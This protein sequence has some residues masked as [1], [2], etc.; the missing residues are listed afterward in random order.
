MVESMPENTNF[1]LEQGMGS[2][3]YAISNT[4]N[5][6]QL[7]VELALNDAVMPASEY[8]ALKKFFE[9]LI[10]KENEKVVLSKT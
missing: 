7:S 6:I 9:V 4:G 3:K 10:A 8:M 1:G 5:K 2:Y